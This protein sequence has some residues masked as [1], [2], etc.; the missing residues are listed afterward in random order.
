MANGC[1]IRQYRSESIRSNWCILRNPLSCQRSTQAKEPE[2]LRMLSGHQYVLKVSQGTNVQA[3]LR[4]I[5][6]LIHHLHV[7]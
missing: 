3:Q 1:H 6:L 7:P 2:F 4:S 5:A